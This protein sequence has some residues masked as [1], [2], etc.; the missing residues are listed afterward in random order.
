M[1][2][3]T[4]CK[5]ADDTVFQQICTKIETEVEQLKKERFLIDV[6]G[7]MVQTYTVGNKKIEVFNDYEVDAVYIDSGIDLSKV[8]GT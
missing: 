6:D 7:S 8:V 4:I 1:F 3:Y 2:S 5:A